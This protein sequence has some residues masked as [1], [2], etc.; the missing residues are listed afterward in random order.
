[1]IGFQPSIFFSP[2]FLEQ[3][4]SNELLEV[5][6][7]APSSMQVYHVAGCSTNAICS[8]AVHIFDLQ[9]IA[10]GGFSSTDAC[11]FDLG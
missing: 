6:I 8:P 4:L 3:Q 5:L 11:G 1:M 7:L 9:P 10:T 2:F